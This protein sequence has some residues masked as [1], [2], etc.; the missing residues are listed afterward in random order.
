MREPGVPAPGAP[1]SAR[2]SVGASLPLPALWRLKGKRP[3]PWGWKSEPLN[4]VVACGAKLC[5]LPLG[6]RG[7]A[8]W[9]IYFGEHKMQCG[10]M[11]N[12]LLRKKP[13]EAS[14]SLIAAFWSISWVYADEQSYFEKALRPVELE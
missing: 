9:P 2:E 3:S 4:L 1:L 5:I 12:R 13:F 6:S 14:D 10:K 8:R 7:N 11:R